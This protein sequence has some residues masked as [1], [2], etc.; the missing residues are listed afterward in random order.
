MQEHKDEAKTARTAWIHIHV[1]G[2]YLTSHNV[3]FTTLD[4]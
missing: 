4:I 1:L 3:C 2:I